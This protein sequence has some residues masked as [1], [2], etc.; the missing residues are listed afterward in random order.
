MEQNPIRQIQQNLEQLIEERYA[1][2]KSTAAVELIR[3]SIR[4]DLDLL[5]K[6]L[7]PDN[8]PATPQKKTAQG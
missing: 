4:V 8:S 5:E 2:S 6:M 7:P 3:Q 1:G